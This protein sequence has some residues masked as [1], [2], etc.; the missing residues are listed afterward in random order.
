M[1]TT[2]LSYPLSCADLGKFLRRFCQFLPGLISVSRKALR[3]MA[4][5]TDG[6]TGTGGSISQNETGHQL[7]VRQDRNARRERAGR[8]RSRDETNRRPGGVRLQIGPGAIAQ[9]SPTAWPSAQ[10]GSNAPHHATAVHPSAEILGALAN[11]A[12]ERMTKPTTVR[13]LHVTVSQ[14]G[15]AVIGMKEG[16]LKS[17]PGA[18]LSSA[19]TRWLGAGRRAWADFPGVDFEFSGAGH[20]KGH[21]TR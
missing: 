20:D 13:R 12:C 11:H 16:M 17:W 10:R 5:C 21:V 7:I 15:H 8:S 14:H 6:N 1:W 3:G 2:R 4:R 19:P 18:V 9:G